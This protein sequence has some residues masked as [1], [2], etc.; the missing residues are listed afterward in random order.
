MGT[1]LRV[2]ALWPSRVQAA[3]A[4]CGAPVES[5]GPAPP[6]PDTPDAP[7]CGAL[8][9]GPFAEEAAALP[10]NGCWSFLP[11]PA[12]SLVFQATTPVP[13]NIPHSGVVRAT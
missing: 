3:G 8:A 6:A 5:Q 2:P 13:G 12:F 11:S 1:G 4:S 9:L 7:S 10:R